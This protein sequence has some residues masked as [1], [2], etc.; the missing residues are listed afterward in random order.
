MIWV[1]TPTNPTLKLV[2][3]AAIAALA[4]DRGHPHR[5]RQ[6]VRDPDAPASARARLRHRR[7]TPPR[8]TSAATA[9]SSAASRHEPA[10][11]RR[12]SALPPERDRLGPRP[13]RRVPHAARRED[14]RRP[15]GRTATPPSAWPWLE[16]QPKVERVVYPGLAEPPAA[17]PRAAADAC[18]TAAP[19]GGGM[20]TIFLEGGI[21]EVAAI[22]R[23]RRDLRARRV[24]RRRRV[25]DRAPRDHDARVGARRRLPS[26]AAGRDGLLHRHR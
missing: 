17:R 4:R 22:P 9:T 26:C 2:D 18:S 7:C 6:H 11:S 23:E 12:A 3:L 19:A 14:A 5:V 8:S 13:V 24:A 20:I 1:E 16:A 21:D 25:A 15:H 10:R